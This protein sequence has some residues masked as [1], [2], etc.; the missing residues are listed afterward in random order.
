MRIALVGYFLLLFMGLDM[1][2]PLFP[3]TAINGTYGFIRARLAVG[4]TVFGLGLLTRQILMY[5]LA[6]ARTY[7]NWFA[8]A[9]VVVCLLSTR[10]S[11][12]PAYTLGSSITLLGIFCGCLAAVWYCEDL[13]ELLEILLLALFFNGLTFLAYVVVFP[14]AIHPPGDGLGGLWRGMYLHKN[15]AG[16]LAATMVLIAAPSFKHGIRPRLALASIFI[17]AVVAFG[18]GSKTTAGFL[19]AWSFLLLAF[20]RPVRWL[21]RFDA[22]SRV[23]VLAVL[24]AL[25]LGLM[26]TAVDGLGLLSDGRNLTG[27]VAIWRYVLS[28]FQQAPYLGFGYVAFF[29]AH[30]EQIFYVLSWPAPHSHNGYLDSLLDVGL[31][32]TL[33]ALLAIASLLKAV[34]F[35]PVY[36]KYS[37]TLF[38][39]LAYIIIY[40][41]MESSLLQYLRPLSVLSVLLLGTKLL[42]PSEAKV[43]NRN[44]YHVDVKTI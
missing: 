18:S 19:I 37:E 35:R 39:I 17:A 32:G 8:L 7:V 20:P 41:L 31:V 13:G 38:F 3:D 12:D 30:E 42:A 29:K 25:L 36:S 5:G 14:S 10:W 34:L 27:R 26:W 21:S 43:N 44:R 6:T 9:Y 4:M 2:A 28:Q 1:L 11:L 22:I 40:N 24:W 15:V 33:F 16:S 23:L